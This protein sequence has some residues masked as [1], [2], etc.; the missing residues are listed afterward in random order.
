MS[1]ATKTLQRFQ[2]LGE[3]AYPVSNSGQRVNPEFLMKNIV[4][5]E[6]LTLHKEFKE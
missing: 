6:F 1:R 2:T 3:L 5:K 4:N